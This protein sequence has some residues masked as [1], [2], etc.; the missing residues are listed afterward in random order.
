MRRALN[1][2]AGVAV[3]AVLLAACSSP[4]TSSTTTTNKPAPTTTAP[5]A[6][7]NAEHIPGTASTWSPLRASATLPSEA[8]DEYVARS[9][10]NTYVAALFVFPMRWQALKF[11]A[12]WPGPAKSIVGNTLGYTP[13]G[14][15][16]PGVINR[17]DLR[18]C[19]GGVVSASTPT[20]CSNGHPSVSIGV[21]EFLTE[22]F[23]VLMVAWLP[24]SINPTGTEWALVKV[25]WYVAGM[26]KLL[27]QAPPQ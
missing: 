2:L 25:N 5:G 19:F 17:V 4:S 16:T 22:R 1:G 12:K 13:I 8:S 9:N 7:F 6:A 10:D 24:G 15:Y 14:P 23:Y 18:S 21:A 27:N 20:L 3:L 26:E 11:W